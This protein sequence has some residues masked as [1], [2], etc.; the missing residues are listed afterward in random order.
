MLYEVKRGL[1]EPAFSRHR[2]I[3]ILEIKSIGSQTT[4]RNK[5]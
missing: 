4:C 5:E 2:N 1:H 3:F